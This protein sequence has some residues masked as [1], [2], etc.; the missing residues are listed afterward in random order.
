MNATAERNNNKRKGVN[1][2]RV[3][4]HDYCMWH[5]PLMEK[6]NSKRSVAECIKRT[7]PLHPYR[8]GQLRFKK[9]ALS[10]YEM[11]RRSTRLRTARRAVERCDKRLA[12]IRG[13]KKKVQAKLDL[14]LE[15]EYKEETN[16]KKAIKY[17]E[18]L[19]RA[20]AD[21]LEQGVWK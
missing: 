14:W 20:F 1:T 4:I 8:T 19:E 18:D 11:N 13:K 12:E 2:P 7:C 10:N 16:R 5:C 21:E 3:C 15:E 6:H 9:G 17:V